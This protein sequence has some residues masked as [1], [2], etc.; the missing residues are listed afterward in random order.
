MTTLLLLMLG[1]SRPP[2][3]KVLGPRVSESPVVTYRFRAQGWHAR[4]RCALDRAPFRACRSPYR[5]RLAVGS[6]T[7]RVRQGRAGAVARVRIHILEPKAPEV[8]VGTAPLDAIAVGEWAV[9]LYGQ[10]L[11]RI[12]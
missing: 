4:F 9:A 12:D 6:H 8:R 7:L 1:L 3:P 2:A 11:A 10:T 5:V